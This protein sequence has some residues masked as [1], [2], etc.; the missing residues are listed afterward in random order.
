MKDRMKA[1]GEFNLP[2]NYDVEHQIIGLALEAEY[3]KKPRVWFEFCHLV[4]EDFFDPYNQF[5]WDAIKRMH[6]AE[7][8]VN[9]ETVLTEMKGDQYMRELLPQ[10]AGSIVSWENASHFAELLKDMADKRRQIFLHLEHANRAA[11]EGYTSPAADLV[12]AA[13]NDLQD[14]IS[15]KQDLT[16]PTSIIESIKTKLKEPVKATPT[17]LPRLDKLLLGGFHQKKFY[18]LSATQKAGKTTL[19]GTTISYNMAMARRPHVYICL[20][21]DPEEIFQRYLARWMAE[22][23]GSEVNSDIFFDEEEREKKWFLDLL[24]EAVD[25]F[26]EKKTGLWFLKRPRMHLNELKS[27][28]ARI[29]LSGKYEGVIIDYVQLV[30]GAPNEAAMVSHLDNVN[31]TISEFLSTYPMWCVAAAQENEKGE[32][33]WGSGMRAA[34]HMLLSLQKYEFTHIND[35]GEE[36]PYYKSC[37]EMKASRYTRMMHIGTESDPAYDFDDTAGPH[38]RELKRGDGTLN[39]AMQGLAQQSREQQQRRPGRR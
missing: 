28:L 1:V 17:G 2:H 27:R 24:D 25:A 23:T 14:K 31:Q 8:P 6:D 18:G 26:D 36:I 11:T 37:L 34:V 35:R 3:R 16:G 4:P 7:K 19:L 5:A 9:V 32:V 29:G 22:Q 15:G 33:R 21:M 39:N 12:G 20:E 13:I 30:G 38:Y 10:C